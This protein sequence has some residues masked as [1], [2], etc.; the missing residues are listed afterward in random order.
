MAKKPKKGK[1]PPPRGL[2]FLVR[3][4]QGRWAE[5]LVIDAIN[6]TQK[7]VALRYGLSRAVLVKG[8]REWL[9]YWEK[10]QKVEKYGKRPNVLIFK[11]KV[12]EALEPGL[13]QLI[14][15]YGDSS[16][17]PEDTWRKYVEKALCA[18]EVE[19]SLWKASKMPDKDMKLPLRK[20]NVVAPMIWVK[21]DDAFKLEEWYNEYRK[22]IYVVQVFYDLAFIASL[23]E[24]VEKARRV[25]SAC[26][27]REEAKKMKEEGLII[28]K[29]KF[30]DGR[31]GA[32]VTRVV[33][34][35]HPAAAKIF[36][37]LEQP[38]RI[39]VNVLED[40]RGK[41]LPFLKFSNGKLRLNPE[42]LDEWEK[43]W[44]S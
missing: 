8:G 1:A 38:P 18:L 21:E 34:R 14:S 29:Q 12:Y 3:I 13:N 24:I 25:K 4:E 11:K 5:D 10:Y 33:Y 28:S 19:M 9:E 27:K 22:P 16:L 41:I 40:E 36:G 6:N 39:E 15:E 23:T 17:I 42:I 35:L 31:T 26:N 32:T 7:F 30:V 43:L 44:Q 20:I 2:D 37:I